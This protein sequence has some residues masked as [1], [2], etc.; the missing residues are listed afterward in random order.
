LSTSKSRASIS[1]H[2]SY[3][4]KTESYVWIVSTKMR[5]RCNSSL[6]KSDCLRVCSALHKIF[7]ACSCVNRSLY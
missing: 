7:N 3:F 6:P 4:S 1:T 5:R 2:L